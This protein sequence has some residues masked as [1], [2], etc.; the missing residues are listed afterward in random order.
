MIEFQTF[1][2]VKDMKPCVKTAIAHAKQINKPFIVHSME[3]DVKGSAGDYLM[4]GK[5]GELY[6]CA[7]HIFNETY[8]FI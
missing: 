1:E 2:N 4:K 3:G 7:K 6:V 5:T 8:E